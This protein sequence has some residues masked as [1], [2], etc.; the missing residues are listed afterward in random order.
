MDI[1]AEFDDDPINLLIL[2]V[3]GAVD[4]LEGVFAFDSFP[5]SSLVGSSELFP[6]LPN[7]NFSRG[8]ESDC[9]FVI[10]FGT[11]FGLETGNT[12]PVPVL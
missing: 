5:L 8:K 3:T 9:G 2:G 7:N 6:A 11:R 1:D 12:V 4:F 10:C